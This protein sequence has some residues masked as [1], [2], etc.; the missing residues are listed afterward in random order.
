MSLEE[1]KL[2][3]YDDL[4]KE[5]APLGSGINLAPVEEKSEV[6][7]V[8]PPL[9]LPAQPIIKKEVP[10]ATVV[11]A[12]VT[13]NKPAADLSVET[14][15]GLPEVVDK[16]SHAVQIGSFGVAGDAIAFKQKM[17][18]KSY[19]AYV[20]EADLGNKGLW[21]RVRIGPYQDSVA[22]K[23]AQKFLQEKEKIKGFVTR[24]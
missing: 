16:G 19:P 15:A 1:T 14:K 5:T 22:A 8:Q 23:N 12:N 13:Q 18:D 7:A 6:T 2:T 17:V 21:Y 3:L 4:A 9:D 20:A 11:A 10:V 24:R